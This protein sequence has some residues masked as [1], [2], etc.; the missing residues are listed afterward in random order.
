MPVTR[1]EGA[2]DTYYE[3]RLMT[4]N[5]WVVAWNDGVKDIYGTGNVGKAV[6]GKRVALRLL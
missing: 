5:K 4:G 1:G 3:L 2:D 6:L